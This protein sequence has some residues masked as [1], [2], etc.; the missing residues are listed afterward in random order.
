MVTSME[1]EKGQF[2]PS[3]KVE[4]RNRGQ[5]FKKI[6][7]KATENLK[8]KPVC[9]VPLQFMAGVVCSLPCGRI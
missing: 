4:K 1:M 2:F 8:S 3:E 7:K 9:P 5:I 6:N